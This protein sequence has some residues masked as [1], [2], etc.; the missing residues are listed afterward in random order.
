VGEYGLA[1]L[2]SR[3]P[4]SS[5]GVYERFQCPF[6][7]KAIFPI[8][9]VWKHIDFDGFPDHPLHACGFGGEDAGVL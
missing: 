1:V 2:Q 5:E 8:H 6:Q 7:T 3:L 4:A 9:V